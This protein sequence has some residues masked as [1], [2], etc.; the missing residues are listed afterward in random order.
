MSRWL[1]LTTALVACGG[2]PKPDPAP[3]TNKPDP[4]PQAYRPDPATIKPKVAHDDL[5]RALDGMDPANPRSVDDA[6]KAADALGEAQRVDAVEPLLAMA[7]RPPTKKIFAAQIAAIR[8]LGKIAGAKATISP[9]LASLI[10]V[11]PPRHPR[12]ATTRDEGRQL[13]ERFGMH[14]ALTGAAINA[15]GA[16]RATETKALVLALYRTPEL[17]M[18]IRRA[19]VAAGPTTRDAMIEVLAGKHAAVENLIKAK[20]LD[21]YCGDKNDLPKDQCQPVALRDYYAAMILGD[22][23]D[24]RATPVLLDALK[25]PAWP[26]YFSDD[27][28]GPTQHAAIF[29]ALRKLGSPD[30]AAPL[31]LIWT[32][33]KVDVATRAYAMEAYGFVVRG[34]AGAP[35]LSKI[36]ADNN[37]DD[38]LRISA[39]N[40]LA[41]ISTDKADVAVFVKLAGKY[42]DAAEKKKKESARFKAAADAADKK[43]EREK[44]SLDSVKRALLDATKDPNA[45][46]DDIRQ[47]TR[48]AKRAEDDFKI[49]KKKHRE[50]TAP[51][52]QADNAAKA[53]VGYARMFQTHVARIGVGI[54]C[55]TKLDCFAATLSLD[56]DKAARNAS[57]YVKDAPK[58]TAEEKAGLV[59]AEVERA[60]IEFGKAGVAATAYTDMLLDAA[61]SENRIIRQSVLLALPKIAKLPCTSCV[62]KLDA[63]IAAGEGKTTLGDLNIETT[64][65][66]NYFAWA[67]TN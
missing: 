63:A 49:A 13:E 38:N 4:A 19:L 8:A 1:I 66:R 12:T 41:R 15:L 26:A 6:T 55:G 16:L 45:T 23:R 2:A 7:R 62:A 48:D 32:D 40:T 65:L 36:A 59:D 21:L 24:P 31:L 14:L 56:K 51:F 11:E 47:K 25:R 37:A 22:M 53:Y 44:Q 5:L 34:L 58:W 39:A 27:A 46:A 28:A 60:M 61:K 10:D 43:F 35:E 30:A 9:G 67:G 3:P 64:I 57:I 29:D 54:R 50:A 17:A 20:K 42:L 33:P 18:Q 52:K